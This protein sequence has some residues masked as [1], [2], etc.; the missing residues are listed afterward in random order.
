MVGYE[1]L[2]SQYCVYVLLQLLWILAFQVH[3]ELCIWHKAKFHEPGTQNFQHTV[4]RPVGIADTDFMNYGVIWQHH[5]DH[6]NS[7]NFL[8]LEEC[9]LQIL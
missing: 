7:A 1:L 4:D 6:I 3:A 8:A 2:L 5:L 9:H